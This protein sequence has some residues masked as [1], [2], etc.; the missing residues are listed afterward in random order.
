MSALRNRVVEIANEEYEKAKS[1]Q[2]QMTQQIANNAPSK[3]TAEFNTDYITRLTYSVKNGSSLYHNRSKYTAAYGYGD[4]ASATYKQ[5]YGNGYF[6]AEWCGD[7]VKWTID[8]IDGRVGNNDAVTSKIFPYAGVARRIPTTYSFYTDPKNKSV[9]SFYQSNKNKPLEGDFVIFDKNKNGEADHIGIV[10]AKSNNSFTYVDGNNTEVLNDFCK[11]SYGFNSVGKKNATY[12]DS[13]ILGFIKIN[14]EAME[15]LVTIPG[16]ITPDK[17]ESNNTRVTA[18]ALTGT[19]NSLQANI[20]TG[21]DEDWFKFTLDGKGTS[22][23]KITLTN[24]KAT[25][26]L[27]LYDSAGKQI[28]TS[29]GRTAS[30]AGLAKGTYYVKV[31]DKNKTASG[32]YALKWNTYVPPTPDKYES[33]N[34]RTA[35]KALQNKT[36]S[37]QANIHT[38]T[39]EDWF[40]FTLA[41]KGTSTNKITLTNT[42]ATQYLALYDS[43]GKQIGTSM[44]RTASLSGLAKGTYYVKVYDKNKTASGDYAL[45]WNTNTTSSTASSSTNALKADSYESITLAQRQKRFQLQ[46]TASM[47]I[48]IQKLMRTGSSSPWLAQAHQ[49]TRSS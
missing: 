47:P 32:N 39:D 37:L 29:M 10:V 8:S 45:T 48:S 28:G 19:A 16:N 24:T 42:K 22:T 9:G 21:T 4:E 17:Y 31:Y 33:N 7:F 36:G 44:G 34:S 3:N 12:E 30:L 2:K 35:A 27:T 26:F 13:T 14:Y 25:Q 15:N 23:N 18:K 43:A 40:K 1:A 41:G 5:K 11:K 46:Q 38:G 49:L 6:N 20:H